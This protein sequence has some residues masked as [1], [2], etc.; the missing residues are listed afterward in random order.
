MKELIVCNVL[1][2]LTATFH[3]VNSFRS[4][5][6]ARPTFVEITFWSSDGLDSTVWIILKL[7]PCIRF[8]LEK[9]IAA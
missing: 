7:T 9:L 4:L 1:C 2:E 6:G 3:K 8:L 5:V